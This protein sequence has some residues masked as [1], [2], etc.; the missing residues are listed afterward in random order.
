MIESLTGQREKIDVRHA[1]RT[2][3]VSESVL[4]CELKLSRL[5]DIKLTIDI[6]LKRFTRV[7]I[8]LRGLP[9]ELIEAV[10][11]VL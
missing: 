7:F 9:I 6:E 1:C 8:A 4:L 5:R 2:L 10:T 3:G 11:K